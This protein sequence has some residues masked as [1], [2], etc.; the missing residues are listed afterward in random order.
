[1]DAPIPV[2]MFLGSKELTL[3][4]RSLPTNWIT[5]NAEVQPDG[6]KLMPC[7][8]LELDVMSKKS[9]SR[10]SG[11]ARNYIKTVSVDLA[12]ILSKPQDQEEDEP[13]ACVGFWRLN[14][15]DINRCSWL[16]DR[17]EDTSAADNEDE[18]LSI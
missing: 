4:G 7:L 2:K 3:Q 12:V 6:T 11:L 14:K 10:V 17:N 5:H 16:P 15:I 8:E 9:F 18:E 1:M 13:E